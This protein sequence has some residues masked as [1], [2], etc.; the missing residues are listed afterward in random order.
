MQTDDLEYFKSEDFREILRQYEDSVKS[1]HPIYMDADDLADIADWY[2][3]NGHQEEANEAVNLALEFNPDAVGPLLY[4]AREALSLRDYE[5]AN[6]YAD[7]IEVADALEAFY[8]RNEIL[9]CE[10]KEEEADEH[11][12]ERLKEVMLDE[13]MDYVYDVACLYS[14]YNIYDKAFEWIARSQGDDSDEFKELMARTLFGLGKYQDSERIFNE[15][16]DH[17]P[18]STR[19]WNALASAQFMREDYN[20]AITSSEFAIAIDPNDPEGLLSKANSLYNLENYETALSFFQKY[21]EKIKNDEFGYLH[22]GTCL[23]NL[24]RYEEAIK[25]L[26][27]GESI[28]APDSQY[29]P[30]IYQEMAFAYSELHKP[31]TAIYYLDK[32]DSMECDHINI[33]IIKGHV[34]LSNKRQS[35]AEKAFRMALTQSGNAPRTML[36]IIVS[37]YDNRYVQSAYKLLKGF[38]SLIDDE[39]K[40]GYSYMALCCL[41]L[42]K[43]DE[44]MK[45]LK[46]A[47]EKNPKEARIVLGSCFPKDIEPKDYYDY[48]KKRIE[49]QD[50]R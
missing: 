44:F 13:Q 26:E 2:Q 1:G 45:Y 37:L 41:D 4:K 9:I 28:S 50:E 14:E 49:K 6:D 11:F 38:F 15:L 32:T 48:V 40:D 34:L 10:G 7:R 22:Q 43:N 42:K 23:I 36:R 33:S 24:G 3:Y 21:S 19:Y 12:R 29:L 30:E 31:D 20:A 5:T 39:W 46:L 35:E 8:L 17:N 47:T 25:A 16:I 18:Y 27:K